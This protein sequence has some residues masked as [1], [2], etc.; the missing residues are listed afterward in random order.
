MENLRKHQKLF[1]II[2]IVAALAL[3]ITSFL[4]YLTML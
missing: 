2:M 1:R 3:I 4:P